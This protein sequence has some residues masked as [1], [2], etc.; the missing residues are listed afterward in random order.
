MQLSRFA[1]IGGALLGLFS[2]GVSRAADT[3][4]NV[5]RAE[6]LFDEGRRLMNA[7]AYDAACPKFADSQALD[8]A[9]GTALNLATC[10]EK[11]GKY[12]SAWAAFRTAEA[13]AH[14]S[15]QRTREEMARVRADKL[16][17][18]L[19]RL[20]IGVPFASQTPGIEI[21]CDGAPLPAPEW[22]VAVPH[23]GGTFEVEARAPGR[24]GWAVRLEL[25]PSGESLEISV[26]RLDEEAP[27]LAD[28]PSELRVHLVEGPRAPSA[29]GEI[30]S[31]ITVAS[32]LPHRIESRGSTQRAVGLL[33]G[34]GGVLAMGAAGVVGLVAKTKYDSAV[35]ERGTTTGYN[36]SRVAFDTG[37]LGTVLVGVG[38]LVTLVGAGIWL[39]APKD[40]VVVGFNGAGF[41]V[42]GGF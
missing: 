28:V 4:P 25:N 15:V 2:P 30:E 21:R 37:N 6:A 18:T 27:A 36:D 39:T 20:T 33:V 31:T 8:P 23:D 22:G 38:G 1:Y 5:V 11:A 13:L 41:Q 19:S 34:A 17:P 26:P 42:R 24:K 32:A 10:Y 7:G 9:P 3:S 40:T 14:E 16:Q 12:A 29:L 35:P